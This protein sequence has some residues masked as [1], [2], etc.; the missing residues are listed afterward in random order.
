MSGIGTEIRVFC[1]AI[2]EWKRTRWNMCL[3]SIQE[4]VLMKQQKNMQKSVSRPDVMK[5][6]V[7]A[8]ESLWI[9]Q[10]QSASM[11]DVAW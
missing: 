2:R 7:S 6:L 3:K 10:K 1:Y 4:P 9:L 8:A 5:S 11:P